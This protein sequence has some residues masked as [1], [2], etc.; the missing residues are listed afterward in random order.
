MFTLL[1]LS[2]VAVVLSNPGPASAIGIS[3]SITAT[4][5][6]DPPS[7]AVGKLPALGFVKFSISQS[8]A[9][10]YTILC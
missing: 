8:Q 2:F 4:P 3:E 6:T 1:A 10:V 7:P 5:P 9:V